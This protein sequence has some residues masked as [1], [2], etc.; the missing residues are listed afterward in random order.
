MAQEQDPEISNLEKGALS[1]SEAEKVPI[2][3]Y[4]NSSDVLM[5]KW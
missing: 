4:V 1:E 3:Y 2:C 5:K